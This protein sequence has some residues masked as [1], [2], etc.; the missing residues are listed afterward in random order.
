MR[1]RSGLSHRSVR[2]SGNSGVTPVAR[3]TASGNLAGWAVASATSRAAQLR[4]TYRSVMYYRQDLPPWLDEV[5]KKALQPDPNRR[6]RVTSEFIF[7]LERSGRSSP[8]RVPL[9][10]VERNPVAVW[11]ALSLLL[12]VLL[13]LAVAYLP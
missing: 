6:Y 11:Q 10:L 4:L 2:S 3:R 13:M 1:V 9:S 5:L 8:P 12:A 7:A